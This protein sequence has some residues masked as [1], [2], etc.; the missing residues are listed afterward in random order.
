MVNQTAVG[1]NTRRY[2]L[3]EIQELRILGKILKDSRDYYNQGFQDGL[4]LEGLRNL[5]RDKTGRDFSKPTIRRYENAG[6]PVDARSLGSRSV[7]KEYLSCIASITAYPAKILI[8]LSRGDYFLDLEADESPTLSDLILELW[9]KLGDSRFDI[10]AR[11][12]GLSEE[13]IQLA[14]ENILRDSSHLAALSGLLNVSVDRLR[15]AAIQGLRQELSLE[16]IEADELGNI[17]KTRKYKLQRREKAELS[18][19]T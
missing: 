3:E 15:A 6:S 19:S 11:Y 4:S 9:E 14:E 5:L 10:R 17:E 12:C 1:A 2:S 13:D 16:K 18:T 7:P 8:D